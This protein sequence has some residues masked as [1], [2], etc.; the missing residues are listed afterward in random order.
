MKREN[1]AGQAATPVLSVVLSVLAASH[2]WLH[3]GIM[4]LLGG[5]MG[6]MGA[7]MLGIIWLRHVMIVATLLM[8][9]LTVYRLVRRRYHHRSLVA[10]NAAASLV[11]LAFVGYTVNQFGW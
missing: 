9:A 7:A 6:T 1:A 4:L 8:V 11:S 3:M 10:L 2:H 5:S